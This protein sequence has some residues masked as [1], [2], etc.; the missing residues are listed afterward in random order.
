M[1]PIFDKAILIMVGAVSILA[2]AAA[3]APL[4]VL[5]MTE[6]NLSSRVVGQ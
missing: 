4:A 3:F 1:T 5:G 2:L 6:G